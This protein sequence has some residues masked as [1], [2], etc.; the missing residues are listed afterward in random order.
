MSGTLIDILADTLPS[1]EGLERAGLGSMNKSQ[2]RCWTETSH[3]DFYP[4]LQL[5][6]STL[7]SHMSS[8]EN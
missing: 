1:E 4:Q 2:R 6:R 3:Q 8:T 5:L 7:V